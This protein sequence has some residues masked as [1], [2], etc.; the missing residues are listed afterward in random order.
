MNRRH[1]T[2]GNREIGVADLK[3]KKAK[4]VEK[5]QKD[6]QSKTSTVFLHYWNEECIEIEFKG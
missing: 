3:R 6:T 2:V 4:E 1:K 5:K